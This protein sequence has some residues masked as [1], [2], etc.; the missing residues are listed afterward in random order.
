MT[1]ALHAEGRQ[2]DPGWVYMCWPLLI[3]GKVDSAGPPDDR[4]VGLLW[5]KERQA[6]GPH[7]GP[8]VRVY[9]ARHDGDH[10]AWGLGRRRPFLATKGSSMRCEASKKDGWA[11]Q[12]DNKH[13]SLGS[14]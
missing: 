5:E 9:A 6:R 8:K 10:L 12:W 4:Q 11:R 13:S 2:F 1:S 14:A 7:P 3:H